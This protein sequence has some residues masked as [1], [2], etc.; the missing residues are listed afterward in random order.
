MRL[1]AL[2]EELERQ[3]SLKWDE[4]CDSSQLRMVLPENQ[5]RFQIRGK[6]KSFSITKP[7]HGQVAERL[8]IPLKYYH[9]MENEAPDLLVQNVNTW[10]ERTEKAFFIRGLG[11]SARAL[12]S[13]RYRVI[14][15]LDILY[16]ALNELQS[17]EAETEDCFLSETEMNLKVKSNEL[18]DF[19]RHRDDRIIGGLLLT[20]SETGQGA[21]RIEPRV[22]RVQ[23][24]NGMVIEE[25]V[26]RQIHLGNGADE[27]DET[28]YLSI[29]RSIR[30]LF[31]RFGEIIQV[32]RETTEIKI[33]N[34]GTVISNVVEHYRLSEAQKENIL[35]A[36][37]AEPE[38]DQY[39]IANAVA[40]AAQREESWE[41][42][43][44][45]ERV[46]GK[47]VALPVPEFKSL[48]E[49]RI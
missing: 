26:T 10:L 30:E 2:I 42:A 23:C 8:E 13:H 14:D 25:L 34:P 35:M 16:C 41:K 44:D 31:S 43:L 40:R 4:P 22:F 9:R 28:I 15:H 49:Q 3:K 27:F 19:V 29:R 11:E 46:G 32:M 37:G 45:L 7:C 36:F 5:L 33:R 18:G 39:G 6:D 12:L 1:Q 17:H 20:N 24:T 38:H 47:L 21:L 48:D